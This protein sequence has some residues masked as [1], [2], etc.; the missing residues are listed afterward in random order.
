MVHDLTEGFHSKRLQ[1]TLLVIKNF[2]GATTIFPFIL[3][4]Y[5][6]GKIQEAFNDG[7][8]AAHSVRNVH[9]KKQNE[10]LPFPPY[11]SCLLLLLGLLPPLAIEN[12]A[13]NT[14]LF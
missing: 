2:F 13:Y 11:V 10:M 14:R 5:P 8:R 12:I 9:I 3:A 6:W 7:K 1:N 4:A